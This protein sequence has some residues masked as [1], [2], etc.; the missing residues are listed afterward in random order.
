VIERDQLPENA[1][2]IGSFIIGELQRL[3]RKF[4]LV[5]K[6]VRGV[7][8]MIGLEFR[9]GAAGF[10][11]SERTPALQVVDRLHA[12]GVLTVPAGT[13]VVRLLPALNLTRPEAMEGLHTIEAIVAELA[14]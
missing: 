13:A 7:G 10:R 8:L 9:Q 1:R 3:I 14:T 5:L 11:D 4:P 12:A 2:E 6:E